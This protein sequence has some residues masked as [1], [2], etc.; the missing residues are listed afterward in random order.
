MQAVAATEGIKL[1]KYGML[2]CVRYFKKNEVASKNNIVQTAERDD[3]IEHIDPGLFSIS[4]LS[5]VSGLELKD[6]N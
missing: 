5:D 6:G 3:V 1:K 4:L 2:D